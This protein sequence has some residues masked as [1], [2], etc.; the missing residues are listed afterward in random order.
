MRASTTRPQKWVRIRDS[1]A[2]GP[3]ARTPSRASYEGICCA[4]NRRAPAPSRTGAGGSDGRGLAGVPP[5]SAP[6]AIDHE[7]PG[8][9]LIHPDAG[10]IPAPGAALHARRVRGLPVEIGTPAAAEIHRTELVLVAAA[11]TADAE[12]S[13]PIR[14]RTP[15]ARPGPIAGVGEHAGT[16]AIDPQAAPVEAPG[17]AADALR[18][19]ELADQARVAPRHRA[20]LVVVVAAAALDGVAVAVV[21][22]AR[23]RRGPDAEHQNRQRGEDS[24]RHAHTSQQEPWN[25]VSRRHG[26]GLLQRRCRGFSRPARPYRP[27]PG[28]A[29]WLRSR[30]CRRPRPPWSHH[31]FSSRRPTPHPDRRGCASCRRPS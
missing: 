8:A 17:A 15:A 29:V 12:A 2:G 26:L 28:A 22:R 25:S 13:I 1:S 24:H 3:P 27:R 11:G 7:H 10:A 19:G 9:T 21:L 16:T 14:P 5:R 20:T 6:T 4:A 30:P 23:C 31:P 18:V